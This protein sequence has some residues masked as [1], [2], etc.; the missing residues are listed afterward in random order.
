LDEEEEGGEKEEEE[1]EGEMEEEEKEKDKEEEEEEEE[2]EELK[3]RSWYRTIDIRD[4]REGVSMDSLKFHPGAHHPQPFY[5]LQAGTTQTD[6]HSFW[7]GVARP[8]R[9]GLWPSSPLDTLMPP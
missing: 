4:V 7:E 5:A 3:S 6:L 9:T 2:E 1:E 8:Y